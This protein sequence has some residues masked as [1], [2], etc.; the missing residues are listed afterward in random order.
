VQVALPDD[1]KGTV[2]FEYTVDDGKSQTSSAK[3]DVEVRQGN[4][5]QPPTRRKGFVQPP[6]TVVAG[7]MIAYPALADW[8]DFDGDPLVLTDAE[9]R[10]GSGTASTTEDGR[11]VFVAG[12]N[13]AASVPISYNVTDNIAPAQPWSLNVRVLDRSGLDAVPP[14]AQPDVARGIVGQPVLIRP[15]ANDIPGSDPTDERARLTL[16][17]Q[18]APRGGALVTTDIAAGTV[19]VKGSKPGTVM[20][21]YVAAFGSARTSTGTIRVDLQPAPNSI[22]PPVAMPDTAVL[23]GQQA[24]T[25][26]PLAN[27]YTPSGGVLVVQLATGVDNAIRVGI[28]KGHW[29]RIESAT[30]SSVGSHLVRYTITDGVSAPVVGEVSVTQLPRPDRDS[31]PVAQTDRAVV[32][33]GDAITIPVLNN[34]SDADGDPLMLLRSPISVTGSDGSTSIGAAAV[35]G[36]TV[37]FAAARADKVTAPIQVSFDYVVSDPSGATAQ[38]NVVVTVNPAGDKAHDQPPTPAA[39]EANAVAGDTMT[40]NIP[41]TGV[42]PDGDSVTVT[43][44]TSAPKLGRITKIGAT[45]L[46]YQS[47][48]LSAGTDSL[49]Y[50]V[51]DPYGLTG[52]ASIRIGLVPPGDLQPPLAVA[53]TVSANPGSTVKVSVLSNDFFDPRSTTMLPLNQT[54]RALPAGV[55]L[56][57]DNR[58]EVPVP[59]GAEAPIVVS[60][61]ITE[62]FGQPSLTQ[63][64]VQPRQDFNNPPTARD[65][66]PTAKSGEQTVTVDVLANDDDP[67]GPSNELKVSGQWGADITSAGGKLTAALKDIPYTVAYEVSDKRGGVA[68]GYVHIP[69]KT[70]GAGL[71]H[72]RPDVTPIQLAKNGNKTVNIGDYVVDPAGKKLIMTTMDTISSS[73]PNGV[74]ASSKSGTQLNVR[75]E[76]DYV[77][78]GAVTIEVTNGTSLQDPNGQRAVVSIPVQVG[79]A[80]PVFR[81][82]A[83]PI[84]VQQG[85]KPQSIDLF[86]LCHVW[87]ATD[88]DAAAVNFSRSWADQVSGVDLSA[89]GPGNRTLV[90]TPTNSAKPGSSGAVTVGAEGTDAK[91]TVNVKV[92]KAPP[93]TA[94]PVVLR[95]IR[96]GQS[97]KVNILDF[98]TSPLAQPDLDVTAVTKLSGMDATETASGTEITITPAA[99]THGQMVFKYSVTDIKGNVERIVSST[100]TVEVLGRPDPPG[101][102][103]KVSEGN[104]S[105]VV[106]FTAPAPNGSPIERYELTDQ[107]GHTYQCAASPC[108]VTGLTNGNEYRFKVRAKNAVFWSDPSGFSGPMHPDVLPGPVNNVTATPGDKQIAVRWS[109]PGGEGSSATKYDVLISPDP[110]T[111]PRAGITGLSTTF[112]GLTNGVHYSVKI[113]AHN[114]KGPGPFGTSVPAIPFGKPPTPAAATATGVD[115]ASSGQAIS[116]SWPP[117]D[118]NGRDIRSYSVT[119]S[120]TGG[121]K[122]G[123]VTVSGTQTSF[124]VDNDGTT[125]TFSYTA[126]N[127]GD[128][129]SAPSPA[130]NP[131]KATATPAPMSGVTV[132]ATGQSGRLAVTFTVADPHGA[133]AD[134]RWTLSPAGPNGGSGSWTGL[135]PGSSPTEYFNGLVDGTNYQVTVRTCNEND[136]CSAAVAGSDSPYRPVQFLTIGHNISDTTVSWTYSANCGG[137]S[138]T[139]TWNDGGYNHS[140]SL[141]LSPGPNIVFYTHDYGHSAKVTLNARV[142]GSRDNSI[143]TGSDQVT[144]PDPPPPP[145]LVPSQGKR[146]TP[147]AQDPSCT[148]YGGGRCPRM[149]LT[150]S[151]ITHGTYTVRCYHSTDGKFGADWTI[152]YIGGTQVYNNGSDEHCYEGYPG[153]VWFTLDGPQHYESDHVGW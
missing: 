147:T 108:T 121:K 88:A 30:V 90:L 139:M 114:K 127:A 146:Y 133:R 64:T 28:L 48:P 47:Y 107:S 73:P 93:M 29:L 75:G 11:I 153:S 17:A 98:V 59:K 128:L 67:D 34:D 20:L 110:G 10:E 74:A 130:S 123:P 56:D 4:E 3:V 22:A 82:P 80:T 50:Q 58:I 132:K 118:G 116:V 8:R 37:R 25:M 137:Q 18:V 32:R 5:N 9:A 38:G 61:A 148:Y 136:Q 63:L 129:T 85:G 97:A 95:G 65:D 2:S 92:V 138:C 152:S 68:V 142:T 135:A 117:A 6:L 101:T 60:Y 43:G 89:T 113:R 149:K 13:A 54:N 131:V 150:I 16:A 125:W 27:D 94:S 44:I 57:V 87:T 76:N 105:V 140:G 12:P 84:T 111:G 66:Y 119:G 81:C 115:T 23:H 45:S 100:V 39:V 99:K 141:A 106:S 40:I 96:E 24:I 104:K 109:P 19:T 14:K 70:D 112:T 143:K 41:V 26:D 77:G 46:V 124:N 55:T 53:D 52:T 122:L 31:P 49:T 1:A 33:A 79:P 51:T 120:G 7:G 151:N 71:P 15:L 102:P 86:Q 103:Q 36:S 91:G 145:S 83:S 21:D 126:T 72:L 78:P 134:V 69:A 144:T 62:G 42:D 35:S